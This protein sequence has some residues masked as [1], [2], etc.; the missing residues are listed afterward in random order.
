M[1]PVTGI[2]GRLATS[3]SH[4]AAAKARAFARSELSL[5]RLGPR[6]VAVYEEA[7]G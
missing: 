5:D 6:Y 3:L 4:Q 7:A 2:V 1:T